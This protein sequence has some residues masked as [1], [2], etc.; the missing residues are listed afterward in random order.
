[1][2][3]NKVIQGDIPRLVAVRSVAELMA[4][5]D[6][7]ALCNVLNKI[8]SI[9]G[10]IFVRGVVHEMPNDQSKNN[11]SSIYI[12]E[13]ANPEAKFRLWVQNEHI[14]TQNIQQGQEICATGILGT[15]SSKKPGSHLIGFSL[16]VSTIEVV[17]DD[18]ISKNPERYTAY[19]YAENV[20]LMQRLHDFEKKVEAVKQA[21][22]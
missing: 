14:Q 17:K 10:T 8:L 2:S 5:L 18:D 15:W 6:V 13:P 4:S 19:V 1:M 22:E 20:K 7:E 9:S 3:E 21:I 12:S 16:N 11:H